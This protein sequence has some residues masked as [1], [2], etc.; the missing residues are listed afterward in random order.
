M[1]KNLMAPHLACTSPRPCET[2]VKTST[3]VSKANM[4]SFRLHK[5]VRSR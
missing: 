1:F 2:V 4:Y 3:V 5:A